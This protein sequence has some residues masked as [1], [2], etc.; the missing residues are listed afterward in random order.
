MQIHEKKIHME[1]KLHTS[2]HTVASL[3]DTSI[4]SRGQNMKWKVELWM[5]CLQ[6][7]EDDGWGP[8]LIKANQI[9]CLK[10]QT[11]SVSAMENRLKYT[12]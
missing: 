4:K 12:G 7:I 2:L 6:Y 11:T 3:R 5:F 9:W 1:I 8:Q 10:T